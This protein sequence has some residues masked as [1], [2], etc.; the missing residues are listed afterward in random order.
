MTTSIPAAPSESQPAATPQSAQAGS[1]APQS[2]AADPSASIPTTAQATGREW[3][4]QAYANDPAL[5]DFKSVDDL[6]KSFIETKSMVGKPRLDFPSAEATPEQKAEFQGKLNAY[7]GVPEKPDGYGL[8]APDGYP[9][10][11][12][13]YNNELLSAFSETAH[14]LGLSKAQAEGIQKWHDGLAV[15]LVKSAE[16]AKSQEAA[17]SSEKLTQHYKQAFGDQSASV[18][19]EVKDVMMKAIPNASLRDAL[20]KTLPDEA[21]MA[22]GLLNQHY[23]K[24]Y[25]LSDA[26][27]GD[28]AKNAGKSMEDL[29]KEAQAIMSSDA[30]RDPMHKDHKSTKE[31]VNQMYKDI[32]AL[33]DTA[34]KK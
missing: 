3:L 2:V 17:A 23:K 1:A 14:Q 27:I 7:I 8:K 33:T 26:N 4:G 21:L 25:G 30:Y 12:G 6:A 5:K 31:K 19:A 34:K 13:E 16:T 20:S 28:A 10:N 11:M 18:V 22:I 9:E 32:G 15:E 24:T 29:R